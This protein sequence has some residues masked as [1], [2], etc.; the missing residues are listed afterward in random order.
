MCENPEPS[1]KLERVMRNGL[2]TRAG[3]AAVLTAALLMGGAP[4]GAQSMTLENL[5]HFPRATL[6]I[7]A[8]GHVYRFR[9]WIADTPARQAQGLMFVRDLPADQGMIFPMRPPQVAKF[10]MANTY[11]PLDM[12]FVAPDGRIEK[13]TANAKPFSLKTIS[14]GAPVEAVIEIGGGE[15]RALGITVGALVQWSPNPIGDFPALPGRQ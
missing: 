11:I 6:V 3:I 13:I 14:S 10:W 12:L 15:A 7:Q 2:T 1:R 8:P 9:A 5:D 4:A